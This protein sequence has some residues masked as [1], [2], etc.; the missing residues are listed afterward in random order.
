MSFT[1]MDIEQVESIA[2]Q[3]KQQADQI[4]NVI[5]AINSLVGQLPAIWHG[6]D[7]TEFV[8]WWDS[9]HRPNLQSAAHAIEGL[10]QAAMNNAA[11]QRAAAGQ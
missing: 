8:S 6:K 3:L 5:T 10:G 1:G 4:N 2:G 7:A 9:Q 11:E